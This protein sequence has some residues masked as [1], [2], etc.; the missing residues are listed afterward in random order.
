MRHP[1]VTSLP[2]SDDVPVESLARLFADKTTSYKHLF[3][4]AL[5]ESL[6]DTSFQRRAFSIRDLAV[7][8][9][10]RAWYPIRMF[11]L[12]LGHVDQVANF[13]SGLPD[14]G[15]A[16]IPRAQLR[17]AVSAADLLPVFHT[18]VG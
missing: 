5:L 17:H 9:V 3:F 13:I 10:A 8:M 4:Y 6:K 7:G 14:F 11:R 18:S 12:S 16:P 2:N 1:L 15:D